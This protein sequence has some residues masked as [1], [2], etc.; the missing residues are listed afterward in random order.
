MQYDT[1]VAALWWSLRRLVHGWAL[2]IHYETAAQQTSEERSI[3]GPDAGG[4][5]AFPAHMST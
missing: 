4:C 1:V 5:C 2:D 3:N